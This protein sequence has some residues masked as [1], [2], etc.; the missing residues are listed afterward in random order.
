MPT[1]ATQALRRDVARFGEAA[2][3][4][5]VGPRRRGRRA[6]GRDL[7]FA[8]FLALSASRA[9]TLAVWHMAANLTVVALFAISFMLRLG[10]PHAP[11]SAMLISFVGIALLGFS[12]WLG[13]KMV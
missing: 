8:D 7:G 4:S 6:V 2:S 13:G 5:A 11:P 10:A 9:R 3:H 12:G 1:I